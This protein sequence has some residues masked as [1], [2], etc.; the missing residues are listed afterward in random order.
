MYI[1]VSVQKYQAQCQQTRNAHREVLVL[2]SDFRQVFI[3]FVQPKPFLPFLLTPYINEA[4]LLLSILLAKKY[5]NA[6]SYL[7]TQSIQEVY[8]I[9]SSSSFENFLFNAD[10]LLF[11]EN[12]FPFREEI[13]FPSSLRVSKAI[14]WTCLRSLY[15]L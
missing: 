1:Y 4:I 5:W 12:T 14:T 8:E 11:K 7:M 9:I 10:L 3:D 6:L 2:P 15:L 13:S